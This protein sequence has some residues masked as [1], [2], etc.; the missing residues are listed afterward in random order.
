LVSVDHFRRE[1]R[2]RFERAAALGR[3]DILVNSGELRRSVGTG[4]LGMAFCCDAMQAEIKARDVVVLERSNGAGMTVCYLLPRAAN[5]APPRTRRDHLQAGH[6]R[7]RRMTSHTPMSSHPS[8]CRQGGTRRRNTDYRPFRSENAQNQSLEAHIVL[9]P[10]F[11]MPK[12][13]GDH[14]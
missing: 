6:L 7:H 3:I 8:R 11:P 4:D 14:S 1:L 12:G 13:V 5:G 2:A 9:K 10:M